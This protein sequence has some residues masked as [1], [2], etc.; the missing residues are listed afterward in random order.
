MLQGEKKKKKLFH[1]R[2]LSWLVRR[3]QHLIAPH[4]PLYDM[5]RLRNPLLLLDQCFLSP[6][7]ELIPYIFFF[8][9]HSNKDVLRIVS[10]FVTVGA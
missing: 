5:Y 9:T 1:A 8:T 2:S 7:P 6:L 4:S 3:S 10:G